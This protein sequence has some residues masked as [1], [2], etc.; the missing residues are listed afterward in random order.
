MEGEG[1]QCTDATNQLCE[2][3][4]ANSLGPSP[5]GETVPTG[6]PRCTSLRRTEIVTVVAE[7]IVRKRWM[8]TRLGEREL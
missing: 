4:S 8:R 1:V 6:L 2:A 5:K 3:G 7:K